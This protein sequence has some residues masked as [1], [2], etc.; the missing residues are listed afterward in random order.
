[1]T[2]ALA[3]AIHLDGVGACRDAARV[4]Q[5]LR[6]QGSDGATRGGIARA[7][8]VGADSALRALTALLDAGLVEVVPESRFGTRWRVSG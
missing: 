6:R 8:H 7:L 4:L 3:T 5:W 1:M 2:G